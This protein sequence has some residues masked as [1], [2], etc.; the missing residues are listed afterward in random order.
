MFRQTAPEGQER[1]SKFAFGFFLTLHIQ[2][3]KLSY[4]RFEV[5]SKLLHALIM[6]LSG[7]VDG[8]G[9]TWKF[10]GG[11]A[12]RT[13]DTDGANTA[14]GVHI[15]EGVAL[16]NPR[17]DSAN[18]L[19]TLHQALYRPCKR[20]GV[21]SFTPLSYNFEAFC[22]VTKGLTGAVAAF[23]RPRNGLSSVVFGSSSVLS[24]QN[25]VGTTDCDGLPG[26]FL[27]DLRGRRVIPNPFLS[28][29]KLVPFPL[30]LGGLQEAQRP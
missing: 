1:R 3:H 10:R 26:C 12:N 21:P 7:T 13:R 24:H 16:T 29:L 4:G 6:G 30:N 9:A 8:R 2:P 18:A 11:L 27:T 5:L 14:M 22:H 20:L 15:A 25:S 28:D 17:T 19:F 23:V